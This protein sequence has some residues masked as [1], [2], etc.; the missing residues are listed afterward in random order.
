MTTKLVPS[1]CDLLIRQMIEQYHVYG[2]ECIINALARV[3][4][5]ESF[6]DA[7]YV[8]WMLENALKREEGR[9]EK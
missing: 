2:A 6:L 9:Q 4:V 3:A 1:N 8:V 7:H 5:S